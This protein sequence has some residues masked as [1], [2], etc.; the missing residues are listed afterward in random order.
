MERH[1]DTRNQTDEAKIY[2]KV[3]STAAEA[4]GSSMDEDQGTCVT[5][6]EHDTNKTDREMARNQELQHTVSATPQPNAQT[7]Q[8][9]LKRVRRA[10]DYTMEAGKRLD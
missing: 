1:A 2:P 3:R 9:Q 4:N 5:V 7:S 8:A 10:R 6:L